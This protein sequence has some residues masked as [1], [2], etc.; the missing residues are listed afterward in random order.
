[1]PN[2]PTPSHVF[3][4]RP[5]VVFDCGAGSRYQA[6]LVRSF[7]TDRLAQPAACAGLA[8]LTPPDGLTV[9]NV[10]AREAVRP[11]V[12]HTA[13]LVASAGVANSQR[14]R[15]RH[16]SWGPPWRSPPD[17]SPGG[18]ASLS[19]GPGTSSTHDPGGARRRFADSRCPTGHPTFSTLRSARRRTW[20]AA[21]RDPVYSA[22]PRRDYSHRLPSTPRLAL[23]GAL[24][25][26]A[27]SASGRRLWAGTVPHRRPT[28]WPRNGAGARCSRRCSS[29]FFDDDTSPT[30]CRARRLSRSF[31]CPSHHLSGHAKANL[32]YSR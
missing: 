29:V 5:R 28:T 17:I 22:D 6:R 15:A 11:C 16:G 32:P 27:R 8:W 9:D 1:M 20:R 31:S 4:H 2:G 18:S 3:L 25:S 12:M 7:G 26:K 24:R 23:P 10:R 13:A 14:T 30:I 21:L 19:F